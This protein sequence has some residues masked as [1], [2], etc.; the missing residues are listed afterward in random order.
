[1][2]FMLDG[3]IQRKIKIPCIFNV[4]S[5]EMKESVNQHENGCRPP[6]LQMWEMI[7]E[8]IA[9]LVKTEASGHET[10]RAF[11]KM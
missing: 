4:I 11:V 2:R 7:L 10:L 6:I 9:G 3:S 5:Q 8:E 1:M